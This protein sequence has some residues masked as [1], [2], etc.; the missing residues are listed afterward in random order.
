MSDYAAEL[1]FAFWIAYLII[2]ILYIIFGVVLYLICKFWKVNKRM[3]ILVLAIFSM[4][5]IYVFAWF[6]ID[7]AIMKPDCLMYVF[8]FFMMIPFLALGLI[9]NIYVIIYYCVA[10]ALLIIGYLLIKKRKL[11]KQNILSKSDNCYDDSE[12]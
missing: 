3:L 2:T 7:F 1:S 11:V 8:T 10:Y 5:F 6:M 12:N 9:T 4:P